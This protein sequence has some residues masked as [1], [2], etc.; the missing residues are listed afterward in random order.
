M[1]KI[2]KLHVTA[3]SSLIAVTLAISAILAQ[4]SNEQSG[5]QKPR[6]DK[7]QFGRHRGHDGR[8]MRGGMFR[9]LNLT[10]AQKAQM[11]QL[12]QSY[13]ERTKPL[14]QELRAKMQGLRQASQ[15]GAFNETL[16]TQTLIETAGLR[17]KLMGERFK[18]RQEMMAA[19]TPEQRTQMEQMRER[20]K[21]RRA[22]REAKRAQQ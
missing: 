18:L 16:A 21:A 19:L 17:A 22:E 4:S 14:R 9:A 12:R 1:R 20:F 6:E 15:D 13:R 3:L 5:S 2:N 11:K 10:D 7:G 8:G